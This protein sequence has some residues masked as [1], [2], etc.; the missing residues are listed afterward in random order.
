M[1]AHLP[2]W[3]FP[4]I[5][6]NPKWMVKIIENP[7][8]MHDLG[9][10]LFSETPTSGKTKVLPWKRSPFFSP[11]PR[12]KGIAW[13]WNHK[14]HHK[15]IA[16]DN[17]KGHQLPSGLPS[18]FPT[19]VH[20]FVQ[21][22]GF[23][24]GGACFFPQHMPFIENVGGFR[25][26]LSPPKKTKSHLVQIPHPN[27]SMPEPAHL[28]ISMVSLPKNSSKDPPIHQTFTATHPMSAPGKR[29]RSYDWIIE[30]QFVVN[31]TLPN[32]KH[33]SPQT[34]LNQ[35]RQSSKISGTI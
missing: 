34:S 3:G 17:G 27:I 11:T 22:H 33:G 10:P 31:N 26:G 24:S 9:V 30:G 14:R 1:C 13:C 7:I 18:L 15:V 29:E 35:I 32:L 19:S 6:E 20:R 12:K 8:K 2:T 16:S 4:K 5:G 21:M 23:E 28:N 25:K